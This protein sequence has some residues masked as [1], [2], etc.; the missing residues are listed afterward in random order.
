VNEAAGDAKDEK[1]SVERK[2]E[3]N[4]RSDKERQHSEGN[5]QNVKKSELRELGQRRS[6]A[7]QEKTMKRSTNNNPAKASREHSEE[8]TGERGTLRY[9][10]EENFDQIPPHSEEEGKNTKQKEAESSKGTPRYIF[11]ELIP[12]CASFARLFFAVFSAGLGQ[13]VVCATLHCLFLFSCTS[14]LP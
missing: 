3:G 12:E 14:S 4:A 8:Q 7:K 10:L 6:T 1:E 11:F 13:V 9:K 2:L 5:K